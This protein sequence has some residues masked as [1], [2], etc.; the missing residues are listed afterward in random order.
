MAWGCE[1]EGY[2]S[3]HVL[4]M[5]V[6]RSGTTFLNEEIMKTDSLRGAV[7]IEFG[8]PRVQ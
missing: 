5:V 7:K 4:R 1:E 3:L 6:G 2:L 8:V